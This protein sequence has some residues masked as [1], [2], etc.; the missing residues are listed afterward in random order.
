MLY[1]TINNEQN[2]GINVGNDYR[3]FGLIKDLNRF[4]NSETFTGVLG[5]GCYLMQLNSTAGIVRDMVLRVVGQTN[6]YFTVVEVGSDNTVLLLDQSNFA[7]TTTNTLYSDEL[8]TTF[9]IEDIL[10]APDI[11]KFTGDLIY[12]DNRTA[13]SYSDQQLVTLR[14]ILQV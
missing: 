7:I 1:S 3:Q 11:N 10:N 13:V 5:S 8:G 2:H 4:S 6:R 9:T 12:I 14:T